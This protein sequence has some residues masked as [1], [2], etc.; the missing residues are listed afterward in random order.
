MKPSRLSSIYVTPPSPPLPIE[1]ELG[2]P[3]RRIFIATT[4]CQRRSQPSPS[5]AT[6][7]TRVDLAPSSRP[8]PHRSSCEGQV[9]QGEL[10]SRSAQ[11]GSAQTRGRPSRSPSPGQAIHRGARQLC[12]ACW[13]AGWMGWDGDHLIHVA[14][15]D[16]LPCSLKKP[17]QAGTP[18]RCGTRHSRGEREIPGA[19]R[20][21]TS[22][23]AV[24]R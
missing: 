9:G 7:R 6:A 17:C 19:R 18:A 22:C 3:S 23:R 15:H 1:I 11:Q 24:T 14:R 10:N 5:R 13:L 8:M 21:T 12:S 4:I 16:P 20:E 2:M